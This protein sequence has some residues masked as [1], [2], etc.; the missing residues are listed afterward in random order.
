MELLY[1]GSTMIGAARRGGRGAFTGRSGS[2]GASGAGWW[3][4]TLVSGGIANAR[5][6]QAD[7]RRESR[8]CHNVRGQVAE[9]GLLGI[10]PL[11]DAASVVTAPTGPI[12]ALWRGSG[13]ARLQ[14]PAAVSSAVGSVQCLLG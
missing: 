13:L 8:G 2:S 14:Q 4:Q 7:R 9:S 11:G 1:S 6:N 12:I 10:E 5:R 3:S